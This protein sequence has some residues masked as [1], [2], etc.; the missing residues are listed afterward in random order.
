MRE[1]GVADDPGL[2]FEVA[3]VVE[4]GARDDP[5]GEEDACQSNLNP[6]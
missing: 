3:H 2:G 1:H 4:A 6:L 5:E